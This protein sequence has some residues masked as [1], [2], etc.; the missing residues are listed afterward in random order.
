MKDFKC[1]KCRRPHESEAKFCFVCGTDLEVA[2]LEYKEKILPVR[3][4]REIPQQL[5]DQEVEKRSIEEEGK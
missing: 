1:T 3:F 2:I 5:I 4:E